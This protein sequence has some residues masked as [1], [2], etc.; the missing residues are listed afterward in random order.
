[1]HPEKEPMHT[2]YMEISVKRNFTAI[3]KFIKINIAIG[4]SIFTEMI[5][6]GKRFRAEAR[7]ARTHYSW[8][9]N[10]DICALSDTAVNKN[11]THG[12]FKSN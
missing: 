8:E 12:S 4:I 6:V 7:F 11:S 2:F 1:M 10:E 3:I 9:N 5:R